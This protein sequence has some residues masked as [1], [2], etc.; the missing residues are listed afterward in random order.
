MNALLRLWQHLVLPGQVLNKVLKTHCVETFLI[1]DSKQNPITLTQ[2]LPILS[3]Q[4][5]LAVETIFAGTNKF[6]VNDFGAL[7]I[8]YKL[9]LWSNLYV[10]H[11]YDNCWLASMLP[12]QCCISFLRI[13]PVLNPPNK[14][15]DNCK[16]WDITAFI[17]SL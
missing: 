6:V 11:S 5:L 1:F 2:T 13:L 17:T 10:G 7:I 14:M 8:Y 9:L 16:A 4:Q 12:T 15:P 3:K